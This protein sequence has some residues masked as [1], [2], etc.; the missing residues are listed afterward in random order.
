MSADSSVDIA[1]ALPPSPTDKIVAEIL[2]LKVKEIHLKRKRRIL[3]EELYVR[4]FSSCVMGVQTL[5][6]FLF[7]FSV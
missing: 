4:P 5:I 2:Q 7:F 1:P 3:L 6:L